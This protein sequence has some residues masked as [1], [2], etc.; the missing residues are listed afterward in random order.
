LTGALNL[1]MLI[2]FIGDGV[3]DL[4]TFA[5]V[6]SENADAITPLSLPSWFET[7]FYILGVLH[8]FVSIAVVAEYGLRN[9]SMLKDDWGWLA[10]V[11]NAVYHLVF[12]DCSVAGLFMNGYWYAFHLLHIVQNND[13]LQRAI[14]AVTYNGRAL[15][16]V[17][18]LAM[19]IVY[20]FSLVAF[21]F[22]RND[23]N[24]E[25]D[26]A[27]CD[28][29]A[30]C[31]ATVTAFGFTHG[32]GTREAF[33]ADKYQEESYSVRQAERLSLDLLFWIVINTIM[34]NLVLG[35]IVDTFGQL[36]AERAARQEEMTNSCFICSLP[37]HK[38]QHLGSASQSGFERHI[39]ED[40]YM[41]NYVY[42]TVY[43]SGLSLAERTHHEM[44]LF[45]EWIEGESTAPFPVRRS[46]ALEQSGR[47]K[48]DD[49][50]LTDVKTELVLLKADSKAMAETLKLMGEKLNLQSM[51]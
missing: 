46:I 29:L 30:E 38:F 1:M 44:Y 50:V 25:E 34:M 11:P 45:E 14:L 7:P 31:F 24:T 10:E 17:T 22:F 9:W 33:G 26:G 5:N 12:L 6:T 15:L 23:F 37:R 43:L 28:T 47:H 13:N 39:K 16:L 40:H 32:G 51:V 41:W 20:I 42:Y 36:R 3:E 19:I 48:A 2:Y 8:L 35:I 49:E 21:L 18:M 4:D 27:Y